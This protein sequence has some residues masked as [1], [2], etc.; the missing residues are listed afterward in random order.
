VGLSP[1]RETGQHSWAA[2]ETG[3]VAGEGVLSMDWHDFAILVP[4]VL[5]LT[6][7]YAIELLRE[8]LLVTRTKRDRQG[9]FQRS[10]L[11]ALQDALLAWNATLQAFHASS[12]MAS[13]LTQT[14]S[15]G[16]EIETPSADVLAGKNRVLA[17]TTRVFDAELRRLVDEVIVAG[18]AITGATSRQDSYDALKRLGAAVEAANSRAGALIQELYAT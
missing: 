15:T 1:L 14:W 12:L 8:W 3:M 17:L 13:A 7:T 2:A 10:T 9:D 5:G 4:F 11:P 6:A 18:D 16:L